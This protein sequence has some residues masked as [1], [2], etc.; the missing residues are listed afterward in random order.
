[1]ACSEACLDLKSHIQT[2]LYRQGVRTN[3][4]IA[5]NCNSILCE[6]FVNKEVTIWTRGKKLVYSPKDKQ[7]REFCPPK[8]MLLPVYASPRSSHR[9]SHNTTEQ[10]AFGIIP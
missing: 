10:K 7:L 5:S 2:G 8:V 4:S 6:S 9:T 3:G 1:M